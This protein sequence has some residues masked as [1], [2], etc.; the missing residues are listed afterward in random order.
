MIVL[1]S[2]PH[3]FRLIR[4]NDESGVSGTGVV[5]MGVVWPNG[6]VTVCWTTR[7]APSSIVVYD[8][9]KTFL[10]IHVR[11]HATNK[12]KIVWLQ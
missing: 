9:W 2:R 5:L 10:G 11:S 1:K 4:R 6:K 3:C 8:D 7:N 12:A